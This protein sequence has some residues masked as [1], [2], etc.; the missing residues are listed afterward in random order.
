M[1]H[2]VRFV[3]PGRVGYPHI[4]MTFK[5]PLIMPLYAGAVVFLTLLVTAP[6]ASAQFGYRLSPAFER[7]RKSEVRQS[8]RPHVKIVRAPGASRQ[9]KSGQSLVFEYYARQGWVS[10]IE[11]RSGTKVIKTI[12][13]GQSRSGR[14]KIVI[15]ASELNRSFGKLSFKLWAWQGRPSFQSIHGESIGYTVVD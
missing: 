1:A 6:D 11:V 12:S 5:R 15:K 7:Q 13:V 8:Y 3:P 4:V 2:I 9:V 14:G 10:R